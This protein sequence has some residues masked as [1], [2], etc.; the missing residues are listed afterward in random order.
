MAATTYFSIAHTEVLEILPEIE[1]TGNATQAQVE[2]MLQRHESSVM[3]RLGL[4]TAPSDAF[5]LAR[6]KLAIIKLAAADLE[7]REGYAVS[8]GS[9]RINKF[10]SALWRRDAEEAIRSFEWKTQKT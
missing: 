3:E 7:S 6:L 1:S 10:S 4:S 9:S 8:D 2:S 5:D